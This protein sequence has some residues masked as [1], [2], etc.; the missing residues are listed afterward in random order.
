MKQARQGDIN[1]LKIDTQN[2][3]AKTTPFVAL[4]PKLWL[5][6]AKQWINPNSNLNPPIC[7]IFSATDT[8][9][10]RCITPSTKS[11]HV[12]LPYMI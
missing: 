7:S 8:I 6:K 12:K 11:Y 1:F 9:P 4:P 5:L 2:G 3:L 10:E